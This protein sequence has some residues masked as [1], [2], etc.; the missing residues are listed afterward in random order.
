MPLTQIAVSSPLSS[1]FH[2]SKEETPNRKVVSLKRKPVVKLSSISPA[3][4][5]DPPAFIATINTGCRSSNAL[6][7]QDALKVTMP[8]HHV[9]N[10]KPGQ[11]AC[12]CQN[13]VSDA[14]AALSTRS[15][16]CSTVSERCTRKERVPIVHQ[17][18]GAQ[19]LCSDR[20]FPISRTTRRLPQ[21]TTP[22]CLQ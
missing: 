7:R 22:V 19:P 3:Q 21:R 14:P 2:H 6:E 4:H 17:A 9:T 1:S 18:P 12:L 11:L 8:C 20:D 10:G 13:S 15:L 16:Q 5:C